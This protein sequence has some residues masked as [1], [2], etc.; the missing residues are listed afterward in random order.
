MDESQ[1]PK[2]SE[3]T[4]PEIKDYGDLRE[5]TAASASGSHTDVPKGFPA[6]FTTP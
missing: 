2:P 6:A 3:Y 5:L 4:K 1:K